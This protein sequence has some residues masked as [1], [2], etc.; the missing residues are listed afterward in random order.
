[1]KMHLRAPSLI[2]QKAG[3]HNEGKKELRKFTWQEIFQ[4]DVAGGQEGH[5]GLGE[6]LKGKNGGAEGG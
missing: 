2:P 1:M 5:L 6:P 4:K 3:P